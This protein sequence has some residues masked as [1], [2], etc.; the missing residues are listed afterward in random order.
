MALR[1]RRL[2]LPD[3]AVADVAAPIH[4]KPKDDLVGD[5]VREYRR[6]RRLARAAV[7]GLSILTAATVT[8]SIIATGQRNDARNQAEVATAGELAALSGV[9][10]TTHFDLAQ[11]L[12]VTAYT[13]DNDDQTQA[14]L[15]Q[16]VTASPI[17]CGISKH[18]IQLK[19]WG[20]PET[21]MWQ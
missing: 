12:A 20:L 21:G 1:D 10:L 16:A 17:W 15:F 14:A 13:M 6:T 4:G 11:L 2:K 7:L 19:P 18:E 5:H 9:N 8:A 3:D